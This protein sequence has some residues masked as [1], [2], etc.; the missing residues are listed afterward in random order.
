MTSWSAQ[1]CP[2]L[3]YII[4]IGLVTYAIYPC[5]VMIIFTNFFDVTPLEFQ[6][7]SKKKQP[8]LSKE[9]YYMNNWGQPSILQNQTWACVEKSSIYPNS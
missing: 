1:R 3:Y 9:L 4:F 7:G 8:M 5:M 6:D 2:G